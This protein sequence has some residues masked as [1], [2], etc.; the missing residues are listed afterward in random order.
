MSGFGQQGWGA[1]A[2]GGGGPAPFTLDAVWAHTAQTIRAR[3]TSPIR[4][5]GDRS[6]KDG[7]TRSNYALTAPTSGSLLTTPTP[8]RILAARAVDPTTIELLL[9][10]ELEGSGVTYKLTI[11]PTVENASGALLELRMGT[12]RGLLTPRTDSGGR[13][14]ADALASPGLVDLRYSATPQSPAGT[15]KASPEGDLDLGEGPTTLRKLMFRRL[16]TEPGEFAWLPGYGLAIRQSAPIR[17]LNVSRLA[18]EAKRQLL[19]EPE[20]ASAQVAVEHRTGRGILILAITGTMRDGQG[21]ALEV[22]FKTGA[23]AVP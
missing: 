1:T 3:F 23:G 10:G 8:P 21:I 20:L 19:R 14:R 15:L 13:R 2:W 12:F 16:T 22:P 5:I 7:L 17:A 11:A 9:A 18:A 4:A 6:A